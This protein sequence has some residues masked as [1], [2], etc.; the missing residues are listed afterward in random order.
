VLSHF[1]PEP[2][3]LI[4]ETISGDVVDSGVEEGSLGEVEGENEKVVMKSADYAV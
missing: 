1:F 3:T 2:K 4:E